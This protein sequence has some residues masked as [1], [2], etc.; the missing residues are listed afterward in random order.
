M[1]YEIKAGPDLVI[2]MSACLLLDPFQQYPEM[3]NSYGWPL[4]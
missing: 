2:Y 1:L 3:A 4:L